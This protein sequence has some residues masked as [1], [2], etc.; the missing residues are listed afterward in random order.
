MMCKIP[1]EFETEEKIIGGV[2]TLKQGI[3]VG[4]GIIT[5]MCWM[6]V[7]VPSF[8]RVFLLLFFS[9]LG[10]FAAFFKIHGEDM[11]SLFPRY[12]RY[13]GRN[14]KITIWK[15]EMPTESLD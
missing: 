14:K 9:A 2:V 1:A 10:G 7:P 4:A 6:V 12:I 8:G 15:G 11:F 5:G 3:C 13:R